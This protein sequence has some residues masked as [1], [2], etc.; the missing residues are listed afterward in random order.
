VRK[1]RNYDVGSAPGA[2][3]DVKPDTSNDPGVRAWLMPQENDLPPG[4]ETHGGPWTMA[5]EDGPHHESLAGEFE[6]LVAAG[7][8]AG[9]VE[10]FVWS[11]QQH[12]YQQ[13]D[14]ETVR[15]VD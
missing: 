3:A 12:T 4:F 5:I 10:F 9:A 1:Y 2:E 13:F 14:L 7:A 6:D 8:A 15:I 11:P